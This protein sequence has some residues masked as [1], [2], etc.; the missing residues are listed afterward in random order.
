MAVY[1]AQAASEVYPFGGTM[2]TMTGTHVLRYSSG[3]EDCS[4]HS[5]LLTDP[6]HEY[7][8]FQSHGSEKT[9]SRYTSC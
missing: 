9:G 3:F 8:S 2:E 1:V 6:L 5:S 7:V 4:V